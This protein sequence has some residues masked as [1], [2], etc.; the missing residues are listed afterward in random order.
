MLKGEWGTTTQQYVF[1]ILAHFLYKRFQQTRILPRVC[2]RIPPLT[3][4]QDSSD[5][6]INLDP[7]DILGIDITVYKL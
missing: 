7:F 1:V 5:R 3:Y 6:S 4:K 2:A